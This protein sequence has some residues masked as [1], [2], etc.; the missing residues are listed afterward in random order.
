MN[1]ERELIARTLRGMAE[2][3]RTPG[4]SPD[5]IWRAGRR[6]RLRAI[7]ASAATVSAVIA[8]GALVPLATPS[9]PGH[10]TTGVSA[11]APF[12]AGSPVQFQ[13]VAGVSLRPCAAHTHGLPGTGPD[14]CVRLTGRMMTV[15]RF[16]SVRIAEIAPGQYGLDVRL[17]A[18]DARKFAVLTGKVA[19]QPTPRCQLAVI[20]GGRVVAVPTV[21]APISSGRFQI[22]TQSRASAENLLGLLL[23]CRQALPHSKQAALCVSPGSSSTFSRRQTLSRPGVLAW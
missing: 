17:T 12:I 6:R 9:P 5:A 13:E 19:G 23:R 3:A 4:I 14:T 16:E 22:A 7:T 8:A 11:A 2:R 18:A 15:T 10:G 21:Q 1:E 20:I